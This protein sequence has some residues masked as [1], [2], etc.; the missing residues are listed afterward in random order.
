MTDLWQKSA[1]EL[2]ALLRARSISPVELL[3]LFLERCARIN[4]KLNAVVT[5]DEPGARAAAG[6]SEHRFARGEPL[7]PLDGLPITVKDNIFVKGIRATWGSRLYRDFVPEQDDLPVARLRA[8][9]AVILGKTNTPEFA[10]SG[11]TDNPLFGV[12]RNPWDPALTPGGSSGGAVAGVA[13]GLF[14]LALATDAG[15]SIRRP[16]SY[17]GLVGLRPSTGR[18]ARLFGFPPLALDFQVIGPIARTVED[19]ALLLNVIAGP[20][21][22]DRSSLAA[23]A[24]PVAAGTARKLRIRFV[25]RAGSAPVDPEIVD[26]VSRAARVFEDLGHDVSEG[27]APFDPDQINACFGI[28]SGVGLRRI[29]EQHDGWESEIDPALLPTID[30]AGRVSATEYARTLDRLNA[31]RAEFVGA[32]RD[33]DLFLTPTSAA[34]PWPAEQRFP[35]MIGGVEASPRAAGVYVTAVNAIGHPAIS[36]PADPAPSG[37]PIG[38]QLVGRFGEDELLLRVAEQYQQA[39]PWRDR[40]PA[41]VSE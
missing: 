20:D 21:P 13:A 5:I 35:K 37:L 2:A 39:R 30:A 3:Q 7:G 15:G 41:I 27:T 26:A 32:M 8:A 29:V 1:T 4:P 11:H 24:A 17:T 9:G 6:E 18:V 10:I 36:L 31:L 19:A 40:W 33:I 22:R 28:L 14:P 23:A 16:A 25:P 12:T 38:L 34:M